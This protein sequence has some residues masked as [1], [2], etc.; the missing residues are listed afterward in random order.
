TQMPPSI[1]TFVGVTSRM[2][3]HQKPTKRT[4]VSRS[5]TVPETQHSDPLHQTPPPALHPWPIQLLALIQGSNQR[6]RRPRA[7]D[8][9]IARIASMSDRNKRGVNATVATKS[10]AQAVIT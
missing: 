2:M 8:P 1:S 5:S 10:H 6:L 9:V 7:P 3:G 4:T